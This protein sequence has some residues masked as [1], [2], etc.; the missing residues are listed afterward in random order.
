VQISTSARTILGN[1][2]LAGACAR[3]GALA[4]LTGMVGPAQALALHTERHH[5]VGRKPRAS[6][7][8]AYPSYLGEL[9]ECGLRLCGRRGRERTMWQY[10]Q[11]E[12]IPLL[13]H[14][15]MVSVQGVTN[16]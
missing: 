3:I 10:L 5:I 11:A 15:S 1:L 7:L 12:P 14:K 6:V 4:N 16:E 13:A 2:G 9:V 8:S